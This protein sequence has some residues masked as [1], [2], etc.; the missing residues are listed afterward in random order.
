MKVLQACTRF[1]PAPGGAEIHVMS[2]SQELVARGYDLKV[3]TS[4]L[5]MEIPFKRMDS[6]EKLQKNVPVK[7]FKAYTMGGNLHYLF[8]PSMTTAILKEK[9]D[10][11][12]THSY[13]YYQ[14]NVGALNKKLRETPFV[15]TTHYHP[16]WSMWG[17]PKR[18]QIR[19]IY[20]K[21]IAPSVIHSADIIIGVSH[22]EIEL[23]NKVIPLDQEKIRY[24]PNGIHFDK[25]DPIPDPSPFLKEYKP[26]RPLILYVGRLA[27]NKGLE[28]L[29]DS[30]PEV[31]KEFPEATFALVGEDEG[32]KAIL[33]KK[34][35]KYGI[36]QHFIFTG[37]IMDITLFRSSF[38]ACD[39][40][41]LPSEWEAFGIVLCEAMA[42]EKACI[43]TRVGGVPEVIGKDQETGLIVE[44]AD[45]K[46]LA[47]A[48]IELLGDDKRR[49]VMG[50]AGR[51]RVQ[52]KFTWKKVVDQIEDVYKEIT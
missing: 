40:F 50:R 18:K 14:N 7:R 25:Y 8:F 44:Y 15:I 37:H 49:K 10:V 21:L 27:S 38:S 29:V 43:G 13:G 9:V 51:K 12:H 2:I 24:I 19:Q 6:W 42:C 26:S 39:L 17:G 31:I 45:P 16:P 48:I 1:P 3:F 28:T 5:Y 22:H 11:I 23:L 47:S 35:K 34:L 41:V 32:M 46:Q 52:A 20:D 33:E 36:S 30:A 4:D